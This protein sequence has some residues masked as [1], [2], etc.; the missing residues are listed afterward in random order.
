MA[1]GGILSVDDA[2]VVFVFHELVGAKQMIVDDSVDFEESVGHKYIITTE[3]L[4]SGA[5]GDVLLAVDRGTMLQLAVRAI[6]KDLLPIKAASKPT[7]DYSSEL[8]AINR[9]HTCSTAVTLYEVLQSENYLYLFMELIAGE[10]LASYIRRNGP[11]PKTEAMTIAY[12]LLKLLMHSHTRGLAHRDLKLDNIL[13]VVLEGYPHVYV[14]DFGVTK[15]MLGRTGQLATV[16]GAYQTLKPELVPVSRPRAWCAKFEAEHNKLDD[17]G[18]DENVYGREIDMWCVGMAIYAM[19]TGTTTLSFTGGQACDTVRRILEFE[20]HE[21]THYWAN[22]NTSKTVKEVLQLLLKRGPDMQ[23]EAHEVLGTGWFVLHEAQLVVALGKSYAIRR[24]LGQQ[25]AELAA[26]T[27][28]VLEQEHEADLPEPALDEL[29]TA[30][31]PQ[32]APDAAAANGDDVVFAVPKPR[33]C[34][35][36]PNADTHS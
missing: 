9:I 3:R 13:I 11:L 1:E 25:M 36:L 18:L 30:E 33:K 24:T 32:H 2:D 20:T 10:S 29:A 23:R 7:I 6:P 28:A 12:Q 27:Q 17:L 34:P 22:V 8:A 26:I 16:C 21:P 35:T 15:E 4:G 19:L 14:T 5:F 31:Q